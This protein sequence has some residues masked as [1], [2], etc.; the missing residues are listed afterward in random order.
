MN[1][2]IIKMQL[3]TKLLLSYRLVSRPP[4]VAGHL[5]VSELAFIIYPKMRKIRVGM[6][7]QVVKVIFIFQL[8]S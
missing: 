1:Y 5:I 3:K 4:R 7:I 8:P 6:Q 2:G